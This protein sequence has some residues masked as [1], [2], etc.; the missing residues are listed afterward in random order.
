MKGRF[1]FTRQREAGADFKA[2]MFMSMP[3]L[4]YY[5]MYGALSPFLPVLIRGLGYSSSVVGIL[6]AALEGA[7][8]AGP[9][10][11]GLLADKWGQYKPWLLLCY[12]LI[13]V[14]LPLL[15]FSSHP[16]VSALFL[17]CLG[18]GYRAS[19]SLLDA[20]ATIN[21][22]KSGSYGKI[23][24]IGSAGFILMSLFLQWG[25]VLR[26]DT[27]LNISLW[28]VIT[29]SLAGAAVFL[30]PGAY[31][32]YVR[33]AGS[34][35]Q[36][37][38]R[39]FLPSPLILTGL[40]VIFLGRLAMAPLY[41]FLSLYVV[42]ELHW[43]AVGLIWAV[44]TIAEIPLRFVSG[45][46]IR[47]FGDMPLMVFS[48]L[49][50]GIRLAV[51]VLFPV[52]AGII[53]AQLLHCVC[54]GLFHP[55]AVAFMSGAVPPEHR[56]FGMSVYLLMGTGLPNL[57]GSVIGGFIVDRLGYRAMF[58]FFIIFPV[59]VLIFYAVI[60]WFKAKALV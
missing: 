28:G 26:P 13:I 15:A 27:P 8:M 53:A 25:G 9:L 40:V 22:G 43:N 20:A 30:L 23:R 54:F 47:R 59:I 49:V 24:T 4:T 33:E 14:S 32:R 19:M 60:S 56:A 11:F 52:K 12:T 55:A 38:R 37:I 6:L 39:R 41:S 35:P 42:E 46:L 2:A 45:P 50:I 21:L 44:S 48:I 57:T 31:A 17:L 7:G 5:L 58:S 3:F 34:K 16:V 36:A 10:L 51:Y 29:A 1:M 18:L